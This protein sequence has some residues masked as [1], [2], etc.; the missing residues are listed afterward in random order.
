VK[1]TYIVKYTDDTTLVYPDQTDVSFADEFSNMKEW[2]R[3]N[4]LN[5]KLGCC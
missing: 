1:D 2:S 4:R 5:K 3:Q